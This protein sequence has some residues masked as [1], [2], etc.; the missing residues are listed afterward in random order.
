MARLGCSSVHRA[1][2]PLASTQKVSAFATPTMNSASAA[3]SRRSASTGMASCQTLTVNGRLA[4]RK[5]SEPVASDARE[6]ALTECTVRKWKVSRA[7]RVKAGSCEDIEITRQKSR[8]CQT[9]KMCVIPLYS[10]LCVL[11]VKL[12]CARTTVRALR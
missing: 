5:N 1:S 10:T 2:W 9:Y 8:V 6:E 12:I 4:P 11:C 7:T 3:S